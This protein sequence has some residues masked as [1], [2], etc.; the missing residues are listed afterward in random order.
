[1][2]R[3]LII[4]IFCHQ[5]FASHFIVETYDDHHE[6]T[7]LRNYPIKTKTKKNGHKNFRYFLV[8]TDHHPHYAGTAQDYQL[9]TDTKSTGKG[10]ILKL[11]Q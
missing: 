6:G 3:T 5:N 9:K 7:G 11:L 1:M 8:E 10:M 4:L 2:F